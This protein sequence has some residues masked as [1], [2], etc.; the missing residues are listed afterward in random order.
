M[1]ILSACERMQ[2][3]PYQGTKR[4]CFLENKE[5]TARLCPNKAVAAGANNNQK[6]QKGS[7]D[8]NKGEKLSFGADF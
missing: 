5:P 7:K 6:R 8:E 4:D 3:G 2:D 1:L